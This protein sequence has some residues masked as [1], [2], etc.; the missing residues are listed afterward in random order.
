M[1]KSI[2][3]RFTLGIIFLFLIILILSVFSGYYLNKISGKTSAI[4]KENY[5]SVVYAREMSEGINNINQEIVNSFLQK[6]NVDNIKI[7]NALAS[8]D[9]SLIEEKNNITEPKEGKLVS[10]IETSYT[11]FSD[12]VMKLMS[13]P[14]TTDKLLA[15]QNKTGNLSVKLSNLSQINGKALEDK[16]DDAKAFSKGAMAKMTILASICFLIGFSFT[17]SFS[18]Y[19]NR[20]FFQLYQGIKDIAASD[21]NQHLFFEGNNEFYEVSLIFNEMVDRIKEKKKEMSVPLPQDIVKAKNINSQE[22]FKKIAFQVK[23]LE[24][25][26]DE[27]ISGFE[28]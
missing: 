19:F 10:D 9:A 25:Q 28:K 27:I 22:D 12:S 8:V 18:T 1:K 13:S 14:L 24:E 16:T 21:Y 17:F 23:R 4:L 7:N 5:L 20:Q 11:E 15:L 3:I 26:I 2:H 6:R